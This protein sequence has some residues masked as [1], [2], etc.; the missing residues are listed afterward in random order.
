MHAQRWSMHATTACA[1]RARLVAGRTTRVRTARVPNRVRRAVYEW[2]PARDDRDASSVTTSRGDRRTH[3]DSPLGTSVRMVEKHYGTLI[4][5]A[6][7]DRV[8]PRRSRRGA[9]QGDRA[10]ATRRRESDHR[11]GVVRVTPDPP[12]PGLRARHGSGASGA[13]GAVRDDCDGQG[14][15]PDAPAALGEASPDRVY[16]MV[17]Q[18]A[19]CGWSIR[20]P[21]FGVPAGR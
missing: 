19:G 16:G 9:P 2:S 15:E 17:G 8:S 18:L 21:V 11:E 14:R 4:D 7:G 20:I 1:W 6:R 3:L 5:G 13:R 10:P 12:R